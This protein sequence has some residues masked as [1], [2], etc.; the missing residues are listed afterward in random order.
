V[1]DPKTPYVE[2][3][4][5]KHVI[6]FLQFQRQTLEYKAGDCDDLSI[7]YAALLESV[8][9]DTAFITVPDHIYIAFALDVKPNDLK[10]NYSRW[11]YPL[12]AVDPEG[13][14]HIVFA[15]AQTELDRTMMYVRGM[16]KEPQ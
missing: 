7:L 16:P 14:V 3:V 6:D 1:V 11:T 15:W 9:V 4:K 5:N 2:Y 8:S 12:I 10:K 13:I